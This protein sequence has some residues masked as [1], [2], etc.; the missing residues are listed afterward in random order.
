MG[1]QRLALLLA[2]GVFGLVYRHGG[3]LAAV[4]SHITLNLLHFSLFTYPM[5]SK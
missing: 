4:V 2:A 5:L 3:L 1:G